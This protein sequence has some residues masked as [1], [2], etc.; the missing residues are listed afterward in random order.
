LLYPGSSKPSSS[1]NNI[2]VIIGIVVAA[3]VVFYNSNG[4]SGLLS[5]SKKTWKEEHAGHW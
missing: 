1:D 5:L 2:D 3:V 4:Y